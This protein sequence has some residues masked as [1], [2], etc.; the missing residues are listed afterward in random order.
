[1]LI[2]LIESQSGVSTDEV[3]YAARVNTDQGEKINVLFKKENRLND[4]RLLLE[5]NQVV[6]VDSSKKGE[7]E[8][9]RLPY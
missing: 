1:M 9:Y 4:V 7:D 5:D 2:K 8:I 6:I 3:G